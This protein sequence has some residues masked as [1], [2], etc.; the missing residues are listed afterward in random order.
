MGKKKA[1]RRYVGTAKD[2]N[3]A[4]INKPEAKTEVVFDMSDIFDLINFY[5]HDERTIECIIAAAAFGKVCYDHGTWEETPEGYDPDLHIYHQ[6]G[7][8]KD[9]YD[10]YR[11][12][13]IE[14]LVDRVDFSKYAH[15]LCCSYTNFMKKFF[16]VKKSREEA[17]ETITENLTLHIKRITEKNI[18]VRQF[19]YNGITLMTTVY[20]FNDDLIGYIITPFM[21]VFEIRRS[22]D[23]KCKYRVEYSEV[24]DVNSLSFNSDIMNITT[25]ICDQLEKKYNWREKWMNNEV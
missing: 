24:Y 23:P 14:G 11:N 22:T 2:R 8:M 19:D 7:F 3:P 25:D 13:M 10:I 1:R 9:V 5:N 4:S 6:L 18:G 21:Y 20:K 16:E 15:D 12:M 17:F